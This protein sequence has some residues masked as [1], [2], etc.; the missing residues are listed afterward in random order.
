MMNLIKR[1]FKRIFRSLVSYYGPAVLTMIFAFVLLHFFP[2]GP[3][4]PIPL[5]LVFVIVFVKW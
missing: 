3:L 5:F 4:W 1:L 2:N